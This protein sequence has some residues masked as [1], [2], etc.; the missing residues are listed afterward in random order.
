MKSGNLHRQ[1][2]QQALLR[3]PRDSCVLFVMK[4]SGAGARLG[5]PAPPTVPMPCIGAR[6]GRASGQDG[7]AMPQLQ[8]FASDATPRHAP[9]LFS[10][11]L[12]AGLLEAVEAPRESN[13]K[14]G[15][16]SA[17]PP[18]IHPPCA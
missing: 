4:A 5:C 7:G 3:P 14:A 2:Q 9:A 16:L 6:H 1:H 8:A 17:V 18:R 11:L 13:K 10:S 12:G 15:V